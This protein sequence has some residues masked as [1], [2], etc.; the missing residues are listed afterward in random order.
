MYKSMKNA[1]L[2]LL[3]MT[4]F[5]GVAYPLAVTAVSQIF[6]PDQAN[7]S[8]IKKDNEVVGSLLIAQ[9]FTSP[10]YF[11]AR[12]SGAGDDG[13]DAANSAGTNLGPTS[14]KLM[15]S[16]QQQAADFRQANGLN[17]EAIVPA[18]AVTSSGSGLDPD[19][20]I[21]N[22]VLQ[23]NRV[24]RERGMSAEEVENVVKECSEHPLLGI[25][26]EEKANVLKMNLILDSIDGR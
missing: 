19:I 16:I 26:G 25:L 5:T 8:L 11:Y 21:P 7:G 2:L 6:F 14:K 9:N 3:V 20:S 22:A 10:G 18:D 17:A 13:Y 23:I 12:P 15:D 24:A 4:I 1:F